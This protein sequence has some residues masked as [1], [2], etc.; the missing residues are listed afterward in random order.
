MGAVSPGLLAS[1]LERSPQIDWSNPITR[2]LVFA[3]FGGGPELISGV[4]PTRIGGGSLG[5]NDRGRTFVSSSAT[6]DGWHWAL[7]VDHP[8]YSITTE[9]SV[10][11]LGRRSS[12]TAPNAIFA[13]AYKSATWVAPFYAWSILYN[14]TSTAGYRFA[15]AGSTTGRTSYAASNFFPNNELRSLGFSRRAGVTNFYRDGSLFSSGTANVSPVDWGDKPGP[16]LFNRGKGSPG[17]GVIGQANAILVWDRELSAAE[18]RSITDN[19]GQLLRRRSTATLFAALA[20]TALPINLTGA[21][22]AQLSASGT[23][24][25]AIRLP[26]AAQMRATAAGTLSTGIR[27]A[28]AA[29]AQ[30]SGAGTLTTAVRLAGAATMQ[31]SA[32]GSLAGAG[33]A[34]AGAAYAQVSA[35]SAL[36]TSIALSG[37]ASV[38]M[39]ASGALAG[40]GAVL[41]GAAALQVSAAGALSTAIVLTGAAVGRMSAAG[42][43]SA[44]RAPI[45][46]STISPARIVIFEGSGTRLVP[47]EGSGN[48]VVPFEGGGHRVTPFEG[49]GSRVTPFRGSGSKTVRF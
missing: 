14:S 22:V 20:R 43:L 32:A 8:L 19:P 47:F 33:A 34:L 13:C 44:A 29:A 10:F 48:R 42:A 27:L 15:T 12:T 7:P 1:L 16:A 36:S 31:V 40:A 37:A 2:G 41:A 5:S 17:E 45:D 35:A 21:A 3:S 6:A 9:D 4:V 24:S 30:V 39:S 26:G 25:T 11:F 23:L 38:R 46:I 49:S 28:G 18:W